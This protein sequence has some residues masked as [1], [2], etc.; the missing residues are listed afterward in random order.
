[1]RG[2]R[3]VVAAVLPL[4]AAA[5][6]LVAADA[7]RVHAAFDAADASNSAR[8]V[9]LQPL[10]P[11]RI[12]PRLLAVDDDVALRRALVRAAAVLRQRGPAT[13]EIA[14]LQARAAA[15]AALVS[16]AGPPLQVAHAEDVLGVLAYDDSRPSALNAP[17]PVDRAVA[18]FEAAIRADPDDES[19]KYNLELLLRMLRAS[20]VRAGPGPANGSLSGGRKGASAGLPGR[21]Y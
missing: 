8:A 14:R 13:D 16:A 5:A 6:A 20:G 2:G 1:M 9:R 10:L 4:V 17:A 12:G 11:F 21:G 3:I 7:R 18:A 19:A 15:E